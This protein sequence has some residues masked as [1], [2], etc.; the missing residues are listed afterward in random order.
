MSLRTPE[1][2]GNM[3]LK[4]Q[5]LAMQWTHRNIHNFGGDNSKITLYGISAGAQSAHMHVLSPASHGLFNRVVMASGTALNPSSI[6]SADHAE[7]LRQFGKLC[8]FSDFYHAP[9]PI[10]NDNFM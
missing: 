1:Y 9:L 10:L 4:D 2:S 5:L 7:R 6:S 8:D 3:G